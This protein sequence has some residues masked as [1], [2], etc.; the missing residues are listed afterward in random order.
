ME[1]GGGKDD[2]EESA[3][4]VSNLSVLLFLIDEFVKQAQGKNLKVFRFSPKEPS[5]YDD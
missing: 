5:F 4:H 1:G 3:N 2:T